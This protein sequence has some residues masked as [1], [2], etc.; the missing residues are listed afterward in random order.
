MTAYDKTFY[1]PGTRGLLE[2]YI[3]GE[4]ARKL[5]GYDRWRRRFTVSQIEM[6]H[7][8]GRAHFEGGASFAGITSRG[9]A[10]HTRGS[11][12]VK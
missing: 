3:A 2:A 8:E 1:L 10:A 5:A 11:V 12:Q 6:V 7:P 4:R 9:H